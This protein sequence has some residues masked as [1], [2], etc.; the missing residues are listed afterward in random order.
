MFN[1]IKK[2]FRILYNF[3]FCLLMIKDGANVFNKVCKPI[4]YQELWK[5]CK[6]WEEGKL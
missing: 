3:I 6:D 4:D 5:Y 2:F 1:N